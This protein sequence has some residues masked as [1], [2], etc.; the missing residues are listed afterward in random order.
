MIRKHMAQLLFEAGYGISV[1]FGV[2]L[3]LADL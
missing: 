3:L 2:L 1:C